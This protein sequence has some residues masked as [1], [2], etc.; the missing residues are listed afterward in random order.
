MTYIIN[1]K[2]YNQEQ[3][4]QYVERKRKRQLKYLENAIYSEKYTSVTDFYEITEQQ[5]F[6]DIK[7]ACNIMNLTEFIDSESKYYRNFVKRQVIIC[8]SYTSSTP[9]ME[10]YYSEGIFKYNARYYKMIMQDTN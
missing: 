10:S 7:T 2:K 9:A 6:K 8:N 3:F 5:F 1:G 4:E